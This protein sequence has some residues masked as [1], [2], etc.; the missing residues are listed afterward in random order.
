MKAYNAILE[1]L[2]W[3]NIFLV[4]PE[5]FKKI[6][7]EGLEQSYGISG[8]KYPIIAIRKGLVWKT[9]RNTIYH[10]I[11]HIIFPHRDH[12]WIEAYAEKMAGGGGTGIYC[13]EYGHSIDELPSRE[14]LLALSRK[15]SARLNKNYRWK[16]KY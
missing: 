10:E 8:D 5:Q 12:W 1:E 7:G 16:R 2:G 4:S 14:K 15:A 13:E 9:L 3:P 11:A 6:D